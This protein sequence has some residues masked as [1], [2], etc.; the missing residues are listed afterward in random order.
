[1]YRKRRRRRS[2]RIGTSVVRFWTDDQ[3]RRRVITRR[4]PTGLLP[5]MSLP[6]PVQLEK[7]LLQRTISYVLKQAPIAREIYTA[8]S[9]A[10]ALYNNWST[11]MHLY[12]VYDKGGVQGVADSIGTDAVHDG[13]S[14]L[15]TDAVWATIGQ[16]IPKQ[17][18]DTGKQILADV[19]GV[20][21]SAE[22]R[23]A[24]QFLDPT[25]K[26][27]RTVH[28]AGAGSARTGSLGAPRYGDLAPKRLPKEVNRV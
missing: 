10:D 16:F 11:V 12:D 8:Y 21:T 13:L 17:Y 20:V 19:M 4:K 23:L 22:I 14:S 3:G 27:R 28:K 26:P 9:L 25:E 15:Q 7:P 6:S 24:K 2:E 18:H 1:M 5:R